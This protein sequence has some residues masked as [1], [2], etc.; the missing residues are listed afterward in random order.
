MSSLTVDSSG[1]DSLADRLDPK[2]LAEEINR[3][4][5]DVKLARMVARAINDNFK[6]E[7]PGWK[8][9]SPSTIRKSVSGA[10]K[11]K[12]SG[13]TDQE[14][15]EFEWRVRKSG[16]GKAKGIQRFSRNSIRMKKLNAKIKSKKPQFKA[17]RK[18]LQD[19]KLLKNT[20]TKVG[21]SGSNKKGQSGRNIHRREGHTLV[22]G[23]TVPYLSSHVEGDADKG[24]VKRNPLDIKRDWEI[25]IEEYVA[26]EILKA[27]KK[28]IRG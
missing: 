15:V 21:F 17:S 28:Q 27:I 22:Y 3:I 16:G 13:L 24:V 14:L 10:M 4:I 19:S 18:I 1:I 20:L 9:L 26:K 8:P 7:G 6:N 25:K 12:L 23:S 2:L 5:G 11:K